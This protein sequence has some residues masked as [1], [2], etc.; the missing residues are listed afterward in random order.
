MNAH[1]RSTPVLSMGR[2]LAES[3]VDLGDETHVVTALVERGYEDDEIDR[4]L[5]S[6]ID[7]AR[8][9]R[10]EMDDEFN[11]IRAAVWLTIVVAAA[12][13]ADAAW[14]ADGPLSPRVGLWLL[15]AV[16]AAVVAI[17]LYF[18]LQDEDDP[19]SD[20]EQTHGDLSGYRR[21]DRN[22]P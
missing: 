9:L 22:A 20:D 17:Y 10:A 4:C 13:S 19:P 12:L 18:A 21:N 16:V 2:C 1:A 6:A 5:H 14:A 7:R 15:G 8:V 11:A 3:D